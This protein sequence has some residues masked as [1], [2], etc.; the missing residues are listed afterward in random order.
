MA[1]S[2]STP[3]PSPTPSHLP[4]DRL[5]QFL[6]DVARQ[7]EEDIDRRFTGLSQKVDNLVAQLRR[8]FA[9]E[10]RTLTETRDLQVQQTEKLEEFSQSLE[11]Q[12]DARDLQAKKL[13]ELS[14]AVQAQSEMEHTA[15]R[16]EADLLSKQVE[17]LASQ[18]AESEV[19]R[20]RDLENMGVTLRQK[21]R[22]LEV[23]NVAVRSDAAGA[24]AS[25]TEMASEFSRLAAEVTHFKSTLSEV[26]LDVTKVENVQT[27]LE[28]VEKC[29]V[30]LQHEISTAAPRI[31]CLEQA[32]RN[33]FETLTTRLLA[34]SDDVAKREEERDLQ[35]L[36]LEVGQMRKESTETRERCGTLEISSRNF[37]ETVSHTVAKCLHKVEQVAALKAETPGFEELRRMVCDLAQASQ[38]Q[39][40]AIQKVTTE[41]ER[42][43]RASKPQS[44]GRVSISGPDVRLIPTQEI[45]RAIQSSPD[46]IMAGR[47]EESLAFGDMTAS[48]LFD[49]NSSVARSRLDVARGGRRTSTAQ[50]TET[51]S[52]GAPEHLEELRM[53]VLEERQRRV[54][55]TTLAH[56]DEE[57]SSFKARAI[58]DVG[59]T[60]DGRGDRTPET[61]AAAVGLG[62]LRSRSW[63]QTDHAGMPFRAS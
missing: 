51:S 9:E 62:D 41:Q 2:P 22:D 33:D 54:S 14:Q 28:T 3:A 29:C 38:E 31:E 5:Q 50:S 8:D 23:E 13:K 58:M 16:T 55:K 19:G 25:G 20:R 36:Q 11:T 60:P 18:V 15:W 4:D 43:R 35:T 39:G 27:K 10:L 6:A 57:G 7:V 47:G 34:M 56:V 48:R 32:C 24:V 63:T 61:H 44:D 30:A 42:H 46:R 37:I 26:K 59:R 21:F 45:G 40:E 53:L 12:A 17:L 1:G 49:C 52:M